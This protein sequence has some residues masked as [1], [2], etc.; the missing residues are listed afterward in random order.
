MG[1]SSESSNGSLYSLGALLKQE[2]APYPG[3]AA[4][5]GR[6]V[7]ACIAT[8]LL[9]M[10]FKL[11]NGFLAVFYALALSRADPRSTLQNGFSI[12]IGNLGGLVLALA[13]IVFLIDYPLLHFLFVVGAFFLA[14]F[15]TRTLS[16][17]G[18][19]FGFSIILVAASSVNIIWARPD[20]LRPDVGI[21]LGTSLGMVLGT[22]ATILADWVFSA[23]AAPAD[24]R[25]ISPRRLF[26]A[27]ASSNPAYQ[28]FAIKGCLAAT[29][30]YVTWA[31]LGWPGLGVCTVTCVI[32]A[33][34]VPGSSRQRLTIRLLGVVTGGVICGMGSQVFVLPHVDS[35]VGFTVPFAVVSAAAAWAAASGPRL[36]YFG[37]QMALAYYLTIFQGWGPGASLAASRDRLTGIV[38]GLIAMWVVFDAFN[39]QP[40]GLS[41]ELAEGAS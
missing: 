1:I 14:F 13:G 18:A 34:P 8:M 2:L 24:A 16:N 5:V 28:A 7:L 23:E 33:P 10:S 9:V 11:P 20:P 32:A 38:L 26:V 19:A 15:L 27:D 29:I 30:C 25:T 17:A 40:Y 37:R 3:R 39:P 41:Q 36:A 4:A 22:L 6:T 31:G 35:I 21:A 12:I